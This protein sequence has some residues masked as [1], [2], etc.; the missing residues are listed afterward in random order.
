MYL[1]TGSVQTVLQQPFNAKS[2]FFEPVTWCLFLS[3]NIAIQTRQR[4]GYCIIDLLVRGSV[5]FTGGLFVV[6]DGR[7]SEPPT[8]PVCT[9]S[10]SW[11][12]GMAISQ[13]IGTQDG[14]RVSD[15]RRSH[16]VDLSS[17]VHC[18]VEC[19]FLQSP[20]RQLLAG[21]HSKLVDRSGGRNM[22]S[23]FGSEIH[24]R[25]CPLFTMEGHTVGHSFLGQ[26]CDLP[27]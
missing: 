24:A 3:Q 25:R 22:G 5:H 16:H 15:S 12:D 14:D 27:W 20:P 18:G 1:F 17:R 21:S 26:Q 8:L 2:N 6:C 13:A 19:A 4:N 11:V 10:C 9:R 23:V 7:V